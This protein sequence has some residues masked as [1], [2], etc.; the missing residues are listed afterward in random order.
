MRVP[1]LA[2]VIRGPIAE[3]G[4]DLVTDL[5]ALGDRLPIELA[6]GRV[7]LE[8]RQAESVGLGASETNPTVEARF[9]LGRHTEEAAGHE[10]ELTGVEALA[11][12]RVV[13]GVGAAKSP[14]KKA[15]PSTREQ[16]KGTSVQ[17]L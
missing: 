16:S 2:I 7:E 4:T 12:Q 5:L 8:R 3:L 11:A 15:N 1:A 6:I 9:E 13:E 10:L 14:Q 17:K